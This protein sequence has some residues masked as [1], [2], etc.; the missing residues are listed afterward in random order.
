MLEAELDL[1]RARQVAVHAVAN[2]WNLLTTNLSVLRLHIADAEGLAIL[3]EMVA[4]DERAR[5]QFEA[6]RRLV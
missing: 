1:R 3:D 6:L 2:A 5:L 4:A